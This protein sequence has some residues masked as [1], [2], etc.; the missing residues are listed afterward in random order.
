MAARASRYYGDPLHGSHGVTQ[1]E[2]FPPRIFNVI[3]DAIVCH[4]VGMVVD[5][6]AVYEGLRYSLDDK[7]DL[8]YVDDRITASTNP[9]W[10]QWEFNVIIGLFGRVEIYDNMA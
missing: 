6:E 4:W 9:V 7:A 1:G 3:V 8:F 2:P 5:N 10:L